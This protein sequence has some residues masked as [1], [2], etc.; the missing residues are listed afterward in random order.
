MRG[1]LVLT[2]C[3]PR[4]RSLPA[5][6][7]V[8]RWAYAGYGEWHTEPPSAVWETWWW[9]PTLIWSRKLPASRSA[10]SPRASRSVPVLA[11]ATRP[12]CPACDANSKSAVSPPALTAIR[13]LRQATAPPPSQMA[14]PKKPSRYLCNRSAVNRRVSSMS[15]HYITGAVAARLRSG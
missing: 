1:A 10:R 6:R 11:R 13:H 12:R 8:L 9:M 2:A 3:M 15:S 14:T 4:S 7:T 5:E